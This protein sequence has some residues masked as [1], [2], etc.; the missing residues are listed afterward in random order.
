VTRKDYILIAAALQ[1]AMRHADGVRAAQ[2]G[3]EYA[4]H[5][6]CAA[7]AGNN[8]RFDRAR[9]LEAAMV[10]MEPAAPCE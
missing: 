4:A 10:R 6:L 2:A 7:L 3:I 1:T 5:E 8:P 9:F